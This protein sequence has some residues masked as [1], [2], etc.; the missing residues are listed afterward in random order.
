[1]NRE[2][3]R[4]IQIAGSKLSHFGI[5][6]GASKLFAAATLAF[7]LTAGAMTA[8]AQDP[9]LPGPVRAVST[10]PANGDV[11][12]YGV[13]FVPPGFPTGG[14][15]NP[16]DILVSNFNNSMNL[17][18]T[19]TTIVDVPPTQPVFQF[20]GGT[21]PLGLSTALNV[22]TRGFVLVG[23]FPSTDGTCQNS[24]AGS[25]LVIDK[26]GNLLSTITSSMIQGPWDSTLFDQFGSAKLFVANGLTGTVV[27]IDLDVDK[28]HVHVNKITQIASSYTA[29]CDP[30]T[31]VDAP[32]GLVYDQY[33]DVLYVASSAD[34]SIYAVYDAAD[35]THDGGR[36][37]LIYT[38]AKHLHGPLG[39]AM[40]PNGHLLVANND[41]IN[42]DPNQ[43]SEIVEFT[44]SGNFVKEISMDPAQGGSFGLAVETMGGKS[45]LAAVDDATNL[46]LIWTLR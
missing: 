24:S 46:F 41:A 25:I 8:A 38:D 13:A 6:S 7:L 30:V 31:F 42:S 2:F 19:G 39:M 21:A 40:A 34:N 17:Q 44:V 33:K 20:F 1:M 16:G 35:R 10:V 27:R 22:L 28:T 14:A 5:K 15:I 29:V 3:A 11:N 36:G 32:T 12:P 9:F 4:S 37:M 23:N 18:G 43:P 45:K 26:N